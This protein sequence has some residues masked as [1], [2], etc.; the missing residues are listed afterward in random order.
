MRA[1][2]AGQ[3]SGCSVGDQGSEGMTLGA[4]LSELCRLHLN[5]PT[6]FTPPF[7]GARVSI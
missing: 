5:L 6:T 2:E 3:P 1:Q 4:C 7:L